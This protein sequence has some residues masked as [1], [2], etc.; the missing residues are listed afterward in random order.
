MGRTAHSA[1]S[2]RAGERAARIAKARRRRLELDTGRAVRDARIDQAVA[3]AYLAQEERVAAQ[4]RV[5][6]ADVK[7]GTAILRILAEG[8]PMPQVAG[9]VELSVTQV[10]KLKVAAV[11]ADVAVPP[12]PQPG[13][14]GRPPPTG[15]AN[16][17]SNDP[18][19]CPSPV[20]DRGL[21]TTSS[22]AAPSGAASATLDQQAESAEEKGR[23]DDHEDR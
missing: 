17:V 15:A 20:D 18:P 14:T 22:S 2:G 23:P 11:K 7:I 8:I 3:D 16:S 1:Q 13:D 21:S 6:A 19:S 12:C 9:L 4:E 5:T 10:Q